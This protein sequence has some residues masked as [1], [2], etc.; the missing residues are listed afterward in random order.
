M[1]PAPLQLLTYVAEELRM[2]L[3]P[4]Y[5]ATTLEMPT[6]G[7][8]DTFSVELGLVAYPRPG[9]RGDLRLTVRLNDDAEEWTY[10]RTRITLRGQF[11]LVDPEPPVQD[12]LDRF[13]LVTA[14]TV[15]YG[16]ARGL[17]TQLTASSPYPRLV[18]P[19]VTFG[20]EVDALLAARPASLEPKAEPKPTKPASRKRKPKDS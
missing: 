9:Q 5:D 2:D 11:E 3:A 6:E 14:A 18:L 7:I 4:G 19:V 10:Y 12:E 13:F 15:L 16:V 20:D 17:C 1:K 8:D